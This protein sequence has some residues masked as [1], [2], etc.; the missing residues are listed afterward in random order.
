MKKESP[1]RVW[2]AARAVAAL[3]LTVLVLFGGK[4][5][6]PGGGRGAAVTRASTDVVQNIDDKGPGSL[7][8]TI[9]NASAGDTITF[10]PAVTGT[11]TLTSGS[12]PRH[13]HLV[14][15]RRPRRRCKI[16]RS[17]SASCRQCR[18]RSQNAASS[19]SGSE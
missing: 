9:A 11:I 12:H 18:D 17:F 1:K 4:V 13:G 10:A 7:R 19:M 6:Y 3:G 2:C 14:R 8:E 5:S 16:H 15:E